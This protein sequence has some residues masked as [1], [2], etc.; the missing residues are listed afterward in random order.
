MVLLSAT[1]G[2]VAGD[3]KVD[4]HKVL[5]GEG[6]GVKAADDD[7]TAAMINIV[8]GFVEVCTESRK[9]EILASHF[10]AVEALV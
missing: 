3:A 4:N 8:A 10:I 2:N 6:V 5:G 7:E 9:W 1:R